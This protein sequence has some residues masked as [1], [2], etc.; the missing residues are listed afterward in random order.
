MSQP[1][2]IRHQH[3]TKELPVNN[4]R[5][6]ANYFTT[7]REYEYVGTAGEPGSQGGA[8]VYNQRNDTGRFLRRIVIKYYERN[9]W[10]AGLEF[11]CLRRLAGAEHIVQLLGEGM[12][13]F[14]STTG[15]IME[16]VGYGTY[17]HM[18]LRLE[19]RRIHRSQDLP[20]PNRFIWRM[21]LCCKQITPPFRQ[22]ILLTHNLSCPSMYC[23]EI[24]SQCDIY[25]S[26]PRSRS[27]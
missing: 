24:S 16:Y 7:R 25:W 18:Q 2:P 22:D 26:F 17:D 3:L 23:Y 4:A 9:S 5:V 6:I 13:L 27:P 20:V 12:K 8:L 1:I 11:E 21:A 15:L 19:D 14:G 10:E